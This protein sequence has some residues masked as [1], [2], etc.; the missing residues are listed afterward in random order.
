MVSV[1]GVSMAGKRK[2]PKLWFDGKYFK[3]NIYKPDG[4]RTTISFGHQGDR[5]ESEIRIACERW[6]NL[7]EQHPHKVLSYKNPYDAIEQIINPTNILSIGDLIEKYEAYLKK[8]VRPTRHGMAHP[9]LT[10]VKRV[11][12]FLSPYED[13]SID[14]FGPDEL[15]DVR[16]ALINHE[17]TQGK[18]KKKYVRRGINDTINWIRKIWDWGEGRS[19]L[20]SK[21]VKSLKKEV[22]PLRMGDE[23]CVDKPKRKRV[24]EEELWRVI[25][26][27]NSVVGDMLK[28]VWHTGMRP[29]EVCGMRPYD[30]LRNDPDCWLY[31]PGRDY[32]P[33]GNHKTMRYENIKVIPLA[34][35]PQR[36]LTSRI[37]SFDSRDY[38][39]SPQMAMQEVL[40]EKSRKRKTPLSC[41]NKPGTNQKKHPMIRPRTHY[42]SGSLR[43]ACKRGCVRAGVEVFHPYDL[44]RTVATDTRAILGKEDAKTLLGHSDLATTELYLLEEVQQAMRVAKQ[45]ANVR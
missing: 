20:D 11:R 38:L 43:K 22:G 39:F 23:G 6:L 19:L 37:R 18:A 31:I 8:T 5:P 13:W 34:G 41:G 7:Y 2:R 42:D 15:Y 32:T 9:D 40:E 17:Y 44:R 3:L 16:K 29:Y 21:T 33:V 30:I 36:I 27:V 1:H 10:F 28:L 4:K 14:S 26:V 12:K 35:E 25:A 45:L 24:T